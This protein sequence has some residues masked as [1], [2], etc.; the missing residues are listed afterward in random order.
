MPVPTLIVSVVTHIQAQGPGGESV[1]VEFANRQSASLSSAQRE[2]D[3]FMKALTASQNVGLTVCA[4]VEPASGAITDLWFP[5]H[6]RVL[7]LF[8]EP[9]GSLT[10]ILDSSPRTYS[11][12]A[13]HPNRKTY[14]QLLIEAQLDD[15]QV[16]VTEDDN[17][18][19][20]H[21][22]RR[23]QPDDRLS[24]ATTPAPQVR[25]VSRDRATQL[26]GMVAGKTCHPANP[27]GDCIPFL[28]PDNGCNDRASAMCR[29]LQQAGEM[30]LKVWN[31]ALDRRDQLTVQTR[32]A[33]FCQVQWCYHVAVG[34]H[35]ESAE[36]DDPELLV[37]DPSLFPGPVTAAE[38][39]A[40]QQQP[41][42]A[43]A[44]TSPEPYLPPVP[45]HTQIDPDFK[46]T[47][48]DLVMWRLKLERRAGKIPFP[49][50]KSK[51]AGNSK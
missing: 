22:N 15:A 14:E 23:V 25:T 27:S 10:I 24:A 26:F 29:I 46:K 39:Q 47:D 36:S 49:C 43:L 4:E 9:G 32:N 51:N 13:Q 5:V 3:F 40:K 38:W 7:G 33:P 28:Y 34:L 50:P 30:P 1:M 35:V 21:I 11:L 12:G 6:G 37:L 19:V 45:S 16:E 2:R 8:R 20:I 41:K 44:V 42:A 17:A 48:K 31:Y 18:H